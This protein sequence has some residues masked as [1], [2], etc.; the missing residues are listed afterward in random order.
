MLKFFEPRR[1]NLLPMAAGFV[2]AMVMLHTNLGSSLVAFIL[3]GIVPGTSFSIPPTVMLVVYAALG[4]L[5]IFH[6][7]LT[8]IMSTFG[9]KRQPSKNTARARK[10]PA[11]KR[12]YSKA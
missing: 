3:A 2:L 10:R 8:Q 1:E 6:L 12:R 11:Q 7:S 9:E 5:F 4:W